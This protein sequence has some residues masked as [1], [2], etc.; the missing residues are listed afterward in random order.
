MLDVASP[1]GEEEERRMKNN[2]LWQYSGIGRK[3][4]TFFPITPQ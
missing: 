3:W 1:L 4:Y 2:V